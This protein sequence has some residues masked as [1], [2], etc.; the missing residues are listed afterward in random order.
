M[1]NTKDLG[2]KGEEL[3]IL[4]LKQKGFKILFANWQYKHKEIDIIAST[5]QYIVFIEVKTRKNEYFEN[6][7]E[8]VT[9]KKQKYIIEAAN[10]FIEKYDITEEAR[11]DIVSVI[12]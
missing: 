8:A 7:K 5:N 12:F 9:R 2:K 3:A 1:E 6:P 10:A 11:F 4:F